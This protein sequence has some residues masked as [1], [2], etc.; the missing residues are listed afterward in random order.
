MKATSAAAVQNG[1]ITRIE[2]PGLF[3]LQVNGFG[4][5][6]F[7]NPSIDRE[8]VNKAIQAMMATGVTRLLPTLIT[9]SFDRFAKCARTLTRSRFPGIIG[10]HMEGP[11]INGEDGPRGAHSREHVIGASIDD[12]ARRQE[13]ANGQIR[14]VTLAP[15][16]PG[17][18][19]LIEHLAGRGVRV[20]I[21]HT[22]ASPEQIRDAVSAGATLSTHLGNGCAQSLPRHPNFIWEQLAPDELFASLIVDGHHLPAATVKAMVRA[23]SPERIMLVTDATAAAGCAPGMYE[24]NGERVALH[25]DGRVS[26]PGKPWLAGSALTLIRAV[27]NTIKFTGLPLQAVLPMA[28]SHPAKYLNMEMA[29]R[30]TADWD[31]GQCQLLNIKVCAE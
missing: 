3:D 22:A 15:E 18:M 25:D 16:A 20:A 31:A 4:G 7:N 28:S 19:Q 24:L 14:L 10:I 21:G 1:P 9:S 8:D 5:V 30:V 27:V 29:G 2:F 6:D 26:P 17:A 23:K 12:F 11:Y 13:A